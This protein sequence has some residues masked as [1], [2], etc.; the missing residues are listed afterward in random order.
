MIKNMFEELVLEACDYL[1][2]SFT[3]LLQIVTLIKDFFS[4]VEQEK[5]KESETAD[6]IFE[7]LENYWDFVNYH[8]L[9]FILEHTSNEDLQ[10]KM[11]TYVHI[12]I[13]LPITTILVTKESPPF[14]YSA[15][16]ISL[17]VDHAAVYTLSKFELCRETLQE[18]LQ[19]QFGRMALRT[20]TINLEARIAK[21]SLPRQY[22]PQLLDLY[23]RIQVCVILYMM[24]YTTIAYLSR[25]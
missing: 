2:S 5:L 6:D 10:R 12:L 11:E 17:P 1:A 25:S 3:M 23:R 14:T 18:A 8:L 13:N 15:V 16:A 4:I 21:L 20:E 19:L 24:H 7:M 22:V 9:K